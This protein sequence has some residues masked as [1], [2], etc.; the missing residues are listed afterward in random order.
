MK[1]KKWALIACVM[2]LYACIAQ[3]NECGNGVCKLE[4][5]AV[6]TSIVLT[7]EGRPLLSKAV[8]TIEMDNTLFTSNARPSQSI[9]LPCGHAWKV[10]ATSEGVTRTRTFNTVPKTSNDIVIAMD[11]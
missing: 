10:V 5:C 11:K 2:A 8:V 6:K 3:A 9:D 7:K 1:S 4:T